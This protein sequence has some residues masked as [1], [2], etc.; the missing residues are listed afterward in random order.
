[1]SNAGVSESGKEEV[2]PIRESA[3]TVEVEVD[4]AM[5]ALGPALLR[6]FESD[7][8]YANFSE[9]LTT[10]SSLVLR[11]STP[12][13]SILTVSSLRSMGVKTTVVSNADPRIRESRSPPLDC[14]KHS[15]RDSA[16]SR[17]SPYHTTAV[18]STDIVMGRRSVQARSKDISCSMRG[19]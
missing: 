19:M 15:K 14:S 1:M 4:K 9:T 3:D 16:Y 6:R 2:D 7:R 8:G 10:R 11:T 17:R 12:I 13:L 18:V 5:P